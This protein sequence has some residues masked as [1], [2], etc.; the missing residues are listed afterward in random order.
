MV[1]T[2]VMHKINILVRISGSY[3][4]SVSF[5]I[6][7]ISTNNITLKIVFIF[8]TDMNDNHTVSFL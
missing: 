1:W 4:A 7:N 8:L 6:I 5:S 2:Y 3:E